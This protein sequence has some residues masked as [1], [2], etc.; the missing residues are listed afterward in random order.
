MV[1]EIINKIKLNLKLLIGNKETKT[2]ASK[3]LGQLHYNKHGFPSYRP[4]VEEENKS[5]KRNQKY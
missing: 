4:I 2:K 3:T 5:N 1:K